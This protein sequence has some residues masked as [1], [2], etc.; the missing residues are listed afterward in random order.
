MSRSDARRLLWTAEG[1][2]S[3]AY[4]RADWLL[5]AGLA[6]MLGSSFLWIDIGLDA[7]APSVIVWARV[8]LGAAAL[9]VVPRARR[10]VERADRPR[11]VLLALVWIAIPMTLIPIAQQWIDSAFAAMLNG[12][13]PLASAL[14]AT[15]L[16]R[17][18][19]GPSQRVGLVVG[20]L[21]II[22]LSA[23]S[24][25]GAN[26]TALGTGLILLGVLMFGLAF[27]LAVPLQQRNGTLPVILRMQWIAAA[28]LTPWGIL[29]LRQSSWSWPP[30]LSMLPLG[31]LG[32]GLSFVALSVLV[33]RVGSARGSI[34]VYFATPVAILLGVVLRDDALTALHLLGTAL[35]LL[36]AWLTSRG[37]RAQPA[38][39]PPTTTAA[40]T[41]EG[42]PATAPCPTP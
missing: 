21:G 27:N 32:T 39:S 12:G 19:P 38:A 41:S 30:V 1:T 28:V 9:S 14:W 10:P 6:F 17:R 13:V 26:A 31:I 23:P 24:L 42:R 11:L 36:G 34:A 33:G 7:L 25:A 20:F 8:L 22:V 15:L 40:A 29:G 37:D 16:L 5:V 35:A 3:G 4:G 2:V 18:L